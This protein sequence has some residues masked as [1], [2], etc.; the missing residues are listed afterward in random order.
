[1]GNRIRKIMRFYGYVQGVGFRWRAIQAARAAGVTG[2][3]RNRYDG[4]VSMEIQGSEE[5]INAVIQ[6]ITRSP[7]IEITKTYSKTIPVKEDER[8]FTVK[9]SEWHD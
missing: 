3:V 4:S 5:Q 6:M 9:D 8:D 2:W 1:M 7:Y